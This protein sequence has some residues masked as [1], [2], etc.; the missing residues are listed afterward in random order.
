LPDGGPV[1]DCV[2]CAR[3]H[4]SAEID[5]CVATSVCLGGI[6]CAILQ[7]QPGQ[8]DCMLACFGNDIM[9][10]TAG[11]NAA[12]CMVTQCGANCVTAFGGLI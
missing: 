3:D 4:C 10:L 9:A 2:V 8:Y 5:A 1:V 12:T 7:C 11:I 6:F